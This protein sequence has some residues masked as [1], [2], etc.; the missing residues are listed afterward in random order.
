MVAW[1]MRAGSA[2]N[3]R[4]VRTPVR[5]WIGRLRMRGLPVASLDN[6]RRSPK[7]LLR[8]VVARLLGRPS[9]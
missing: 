9:R 4:D 2:G 7:A 5:T 6:G 1:V 8:T 3:A